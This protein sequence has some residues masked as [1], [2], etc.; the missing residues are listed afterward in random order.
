MHNF[1]MDFSEGMT[2]QETSKGEYGPY[3]QSERAEIYRTFAKDLLLKGLA[4]PDFC[5]SRR[6]SCFKRRANS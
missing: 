5:T 6:I 4:Y 3:R 2:G 1:G